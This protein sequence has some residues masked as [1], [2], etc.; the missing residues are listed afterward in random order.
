ME[1]VKRRGIG[2]QLGAHLGLNAQE[3]LR[4]TRPE[5]LH[6]V[7]PWIE[8][9]NDDTKD[10]WYKRVDQAEMDEYHDAV[11]KTFAPQIRRGV[12]EIHRMKSWDALAGFADNSV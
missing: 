11:A 3:L 1:C 6:L 9:R 12:V 10:S 5:K 7:D 4:Q 2:V 8:I